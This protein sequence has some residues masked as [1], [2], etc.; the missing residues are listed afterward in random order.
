MIVAVASISVPSNDGVRTS[1]YLMNN[2]VVIVRRVLIDDTN[3][4]I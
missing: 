1:P 4:E 2:Y 3:D